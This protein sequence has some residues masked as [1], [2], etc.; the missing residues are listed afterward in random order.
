MLGRYQSPDEY[1]VEAFKALG[2]P[3]RLDI[4]LRMARVDEL[5][6]TELEKV[7]PVSKSTISY[8]MK[9]LGR[10]GLVDVRKDGRYYFYT[11]RPDAIGAVIPDFWARLLELTSESEPVMTPAKV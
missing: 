1:V 10:A 6:C 7:L 11:V 5:A 3:L 2:D 8:H 9:V 4:M